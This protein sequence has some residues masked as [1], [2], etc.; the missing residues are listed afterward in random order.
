MRA[1]RTVTCAPIELRLITPRDAARLHAIAR[2]PDATRMVQW[3]AHHTIETSLEFVHDTQRLW[4]RRVAWIAGVYR[5]EDGT[6]MGTI[7]I[8]GIDRVN[9]R[10]EVG[11]WLG[12]PY[13]GRGYNRAIKAAAL[14]FCFTAL[15]L[16]RVEFLTRV[17]N[18]PALRAMRRLPSIR[19]E[20]R[21][22]ERLHKDGTAH[23][24]VLFALLK[25]DFD[26]AHWP[27]AMIG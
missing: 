27:M 10:A 22:A 17:D 26:A 4:Q 9:A 2:D 16:N 23:D 1:P 11:T 13:R 3:D 20:G 8:S 21:L 25:R 12:T 24:A 14:T 18:E 6:L 5:S 19:E 15:D 7:S